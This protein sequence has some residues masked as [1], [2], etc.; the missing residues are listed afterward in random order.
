MVRRTPVDWAVQ[1]C[2]LGLSM[3]SLASVSPYVPDGSFTG[4]ISY[5]GFSL[6]NEISQLTPRDEKPFTLRIM[7]LGASITYGYQSTDGNGYRRWLRQ[8]LRHAGWWVNMVG[9]NPNDTSTMNN[10]E[11]EATS[12]FRVDQ[13]T[14]EAEKTIP[15]QPNL[16][17]TGERLDALLTRLFDAIPGTTIILSTLLPIV[18][19][20]EVVHFAKYISDQYRQ[21]IAAC[22]QQGQRIILTEMTN[23]IK[24]EDLIDGTHLTDFGY[25]KMALAWWEVIQDTELQRLLQSPNNTGVSGTGRTTCKKEYG[26]GNKRGRVQTQRGSGADD[27]NYVHSS[28]DM[29]RIF[30]PA[31]TKEEKDFALGIN[32]AQLVNKFGAHRESALDELVWT[33]GGN[34][35]YMF[36]HNNDGKFGSVVRIEVNDGCLAR[37][38]RW[39][40]VSGDGLDDFI[41]ISREGHM[42]VSIN[43]DKDPNVPTFRSIGL[44]KDRLGDIGGDGRIDYCLIHKNGDIRCWHN[45]GQKDA[46]TKEYGG[47]WQDL[48]IVF[49]GKG[50]GD[51]TGVPLV[52]INRDFRSDWL[53]LDA[54]GKSDLWAVKRDT[55]EAEVWLNKWSSNAQGDYFQFKGV[56][57]GNA[58]CTQGWG[59]G[60]YDLGLRFADLDGDGRA[61][62][63]CMDP[64]GRTDGWLNKGDNSFESIG[65]VKRSE[66]YDRANH[67]WADVNDG[68]MAD[69]LW[70]DKFNGDTTVAI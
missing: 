29:G 53:W 12:G 42:Y 16:I 31:T 65:Q 62:Y 5:D 44:V 55:G 10:N 9:S 4:I 15:P 40:D 57:T 61:N 51:I 54:K 45:G 26:S 30:S 21:I 68:R 49:K 69:F 41:C 11:V 22:R 38:V 46:P 20:R 35:T 6:L 48:G 25:K 58:R 8:Q 67:R 64:D 34:G 43:E 19:E 1:T 33:K 70:I 7:P 13:F 27:G 63:L 28:K 14:Q 36:I 18:A 17:L 2:I 32:Y 52:D 59:V 39:G 66:H 23:F 50:M 47:Y 24:I 56:L 37:G 3:L 60:L